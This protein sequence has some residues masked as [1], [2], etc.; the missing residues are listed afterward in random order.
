MLKVFWHRYGSIP[1]SLDSD[2][3]MRVETPGLKPI[4][5]QLIITIINSNIFIFED[6]FC[7]CNTKSA[8]FSIHCSVMYATTLPSF[9]GKQNQ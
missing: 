8:L 2:L 7:V 3:V 4:T 5:L 9:N 6:G 1:T